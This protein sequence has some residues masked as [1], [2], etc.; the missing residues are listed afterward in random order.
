M[1]SYWINILDAIWQATAIFFIAYFSYA[2]Y[3]NIDSF[4]F[5]CSLVLSMILISMVHVGLQAT[6]I[7]LVLISSM[8]LSILLFFVFT[9]IY[10]ATCLTCLNGQNSYGVAYSAFNQPIFW[11]TNLLTIIT[12]LL[13]RFIIKC[14]YNSTTNPFLRDNKKNL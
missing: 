7:D 2:N 11:F 8:V 9:L 12:A 6:R 1:S 3:A 5:G 10:D 4:S 14:I 13:P